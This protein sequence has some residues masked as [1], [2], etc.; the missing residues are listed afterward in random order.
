MAVLTRI[1]DSVNDADHIVSAVPPG[2]EKEQLRYALGNLMGTL[3][4]DLMRPI[5]REYPH[6]DPDK[7]TDWFR[8]L[9]RRRGGQ[10]PESQDEDV[11]R[12]NEQVQH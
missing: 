1:G 4:L 6:L 11:L 10:S 12:C 7:D 8:D 2:P 3:W 9:Q 5:V